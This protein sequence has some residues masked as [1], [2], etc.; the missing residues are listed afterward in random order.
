MAEMLAVVPT[1]QTA[2]RER[3]PQRRWGCLRMRDNLIFAVSRSQFSLRNT[4][5]FHSG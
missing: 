4:D 1:S 3:P 2:L 5:P